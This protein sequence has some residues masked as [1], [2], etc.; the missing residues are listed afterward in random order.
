MPEIQKIQ[1][2]IIELRWTKWVQWQVL[3]LDGPNPQ[4]AEI[5]KDPGVYE[6]RIDKQ[7]QRLTIGKASNLRS[8][9]KYGLV[10]GT[11]PHSAGKKIRSF[12]NVKKIK[13]RWAYTDRQAAA[14]EELHRL[15]KESNQ[16]KLPKYTERT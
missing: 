10:K 6:A 3:T 8:R 12:E 5:G 2:P 16:G 1:I 9:I 7:G 15:H 13:I 11:I 14:E 4:A